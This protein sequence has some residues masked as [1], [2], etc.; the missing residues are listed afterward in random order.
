MAYEVNERVMI[1]AGYGYH[2]TTHYP[3]GGKF[4]RASEPLPGVVIGRYQREIVMKLD[5]GREATVNVVSLTPA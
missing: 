1:R 3:R 5:D 2:D 4:C